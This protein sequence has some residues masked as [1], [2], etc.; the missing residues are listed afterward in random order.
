MVKTQISLTGRIS[1]CKKGFTFLE[2]LFVLV[3]I[4]LIL[5][6]VIPNFHQMFKSIVGAREGNKILQLLKK[7]RAEA[8]IRAEPVEITFYTTGKAGLKL[9]EKLVE[10]QDVHLIVKLDEAD[11]DCVIQK[12]YPDG[13]ALHQFLNF[14]SQ[15]GKS[16]RY[17]FHPITGEIEMERS[18]ALCED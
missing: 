10:Y 18:L 13:T 14:S 15:Q 6:L 7:A 5:S 1:S 11:A 17:T 3:I 9:G 12:F 4:S 8:I 2:I 16:V